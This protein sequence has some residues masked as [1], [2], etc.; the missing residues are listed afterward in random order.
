MRNGIVL[1]TSD[2]GIT[3]AVLGKAAEERGFLFTLFGKFKLFDTKPVFR[4]TNF[5]VC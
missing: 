1:F 2:R 4:L 3:P 5:F